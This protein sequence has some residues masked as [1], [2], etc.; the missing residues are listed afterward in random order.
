MK[1]IIAILSVAVL[2]FAACDKINPNEYTTTTGGGG[3]SNWE[4]FNVQ[5]ALVEKYT[6]PKCPNCP[7]A[8]VTLDAAHAQYGDR[9]IVISVNHPTG[10]G[11]PFA[12]QPDLRTDDGTAWDTWLGIN[13]IPSA[14]LNR[15]RS[16][17]YTGSMSDIV[18]AIGDVVERYPLCGIGVT[19]TATDDSIAIDVDIEFFS[20]IEGATTLT[21]ALT[22]DAL[23]YKQSMP[24]GSRQD[25][26]VHNHMLRDVITATFGDDVPLQGVAGEHKVGH[27]SYH[28]PDTDP[29]IVLSNCHIV[30]FLSYR[31]SRKIINSAECIIQNKQ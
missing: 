15:D 10:Q 20:T 9:L 13:S 6:G 4:N 26:Y 5:R 29:A 12:N 22:E 31:D 30:A 1:N 18:A 25:D 23:V 28:I 3:S 2:L 24:D 17:Q 21:L 27:Y 8:D 16:R 19:A 7:N 14:Y 11:E